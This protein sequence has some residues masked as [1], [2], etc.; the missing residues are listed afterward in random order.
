ML[1]AITT[2]LMSSRWRRRG[3][4]LGRLVGMRVKLHSGS[5]WVKEASNFTDLTTADLD[6]GH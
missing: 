4:F 6:R 3:P 1:M 5:T 2:H